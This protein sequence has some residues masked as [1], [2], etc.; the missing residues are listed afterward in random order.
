[1][2]FFLQPDTQDKL[3]MAVN[4]SK[5]MKHTGIQIVCLQYSY[6]GLASLNMQKSVSRVSFVKRKF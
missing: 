4:N 5:H 3:T 1:M 6:I 2:I